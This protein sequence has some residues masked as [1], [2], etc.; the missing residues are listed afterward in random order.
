ME[1]MCVSGTFP[2]K[3]RVTRVFTETTIPA[4]VKII[5]NEYG[6][7]FIG[8][9]HKQVFSQLAITGVSYWEWI[10]EQ[11]QRIGYGVIIDGMNFFFRPLDKLIDEGFSSAAILSMG[12]A[13]APFN[14][15]F[16]DRTLDSFKV[17]SGD[18]V[19]DT[20]NYRAIKNVGGV[21]PLK[22]RSIISS[23]TPAS[24]G[25]NLRTSTS[26]VLFSEYRTDRVINDD[27][28]AAAAAEG[29]AQMARFNLPARVQCQGDPRIR[30]FGTVYISGTGN[31]TDGFWVVREAHHMFHK[32]GDYQMD[33]KI[34]TDGVGATV[35]TPFRS[36]TDITS[37][38]INLDSVVNNGGIPPL[39]FEMTS[40]E[41]TGNTVVKEGNQGFLK[42]PNKWK[43]V[44]A[45][46]ER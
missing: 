41:L 30:P 29:A 20:V 1:V 15:Q 31:L 19:E 23:S 38:S 2:L 21:D 11:A 27:D 8:D 12:N 17:N 44:G 16:M 40:V 25:T 26:D 13:T 42:N 10:C 22:A 9:Q 46:Y 18:N 6:F 35:E 7:N 28:A 3:E 36:R 32:I 34:S 33:L 37:G 5:A 45:Q 14:T 39:F 24:V 4:A 43:Y